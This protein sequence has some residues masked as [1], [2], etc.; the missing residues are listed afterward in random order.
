M[1]RLCS[2]LLVG[3]LVLAGVFAIASLAVGLFGSANPAGADGACTI[4]WAGPT[5]GG[6]WSTTSNWLP[7]RIPA[8]SDVVCIGEAVGGDQG[9][10]GTVVFDGSNGTS[11]TLV[12]ELRSTAPL[13]ITGGELALTDTSATQNVVG[14]FALSG[15]QLGDTTNNQGSF[16]DTGSFS[17]TSGVIEAPTS[18]SPQPVVTDTSTSVPAT[19][20]NVEALSNWNL[21]FDGPMSIT[22]AWFQN[23]GGITE[24]GAATLNNG[25]NISPN[26]NATPA[27]FTLTSTGSLTVGSGSAASA[28]LS[29]PIAASVGAVTV[30]AGDTL[31]VN[32]GGSLGSFAVN[33]GATL[34]LN[35][36]V[37][38]GPGSESGSGT[39]SVVG[40][41]TTIN[42]ALNF[43]GTVTVPSGELYIP[44][45]VSGSQVTNLSLSGGQLGDTTNNQGSL[46]VSGSFSWTSGVIEAP[47]SQS[48]QP[49][50]TDT[51][52]SVPATIG[53]V[54]VLSN[55]NLHFDGPMSITA[56]WFQNGGGITEAGAATLNN[57]AY[58]TANG[59]ATPAPFTLTSTGSLTVG[60][61]S[62]ASATVSV[63]IAAS[64][65]TVTVPAGDTLNVNDGGSLGSFA[66]NAG[67]TLG[68][69]GAM[70]IGPGTKTGS[71]TITVEG[72]ITTINSSLSFPGTV[73]VP[74]GEL[75]IPS[76]VTGSQVGG[77]ALSGGQLG[78]T[79][80]NQ[81]SFTDTGSFSWTSGVIEAPTSQSPQPVV[82]DT[83]TSVP[84]T[85][86][87]VEA[88]SNW[89]LHFDGPMSITAAWFQ[90]GGGITEAGAA[91]LNNGAYITAN[92]NPSP[93][94]FTLTNTAS[95]TVGSGASASATVSVPIAA[96][97]ATVTVPAG[98]TLNLGN[99]PNSGSVGNFTVGNGGTLGLDNVN[100]AASTTNSG[101]GTVNFSGT[102]AD[103]A[104]LDVANA[105]V[106]NGVTTANAALTLAGTLS[107][108]GGELS[109]PSSVTGSQVGGFA[110]SGG[111]LGDTTNNQGSFTDTGS[112]SWTS[113]VIE[114]PTSQSPQ[115][116][117]TDT[118][119]SVP[120]TISNVEALSN[121]NL[122]FDGPMSITAAWFQNGG[123]ITE[124]GAATLNNGA[125]IT[126]NGNPSPGTFTLTNT[127]S[128]TVGS[129][130]SASATVSVP[131]AAAT[132]TVTVPAGDTLN[133]GNAPNSGSVGNFTVGNGG[134][135][136]LDNVNI[137][138]STTNSG[139]GTVNFSGTVA[140][141][142]ALD[143]ANA[144]VI[145]GVTTANAALTLA[146]TLSI[147][148]GE[149]SIPSSVTGSQVGGFALSGGQLGDTTN[150]QGSFTDTGS[151]SWT[152]GVIEA[153]TS[154]SPQP[155]VT[156]TST[157]VP[158]TISNVEALSNWNLHFDGPMSITAAWFQNGG[159]ITEAGAATLNN[160]A[161]ITANGNPSPGTFTLTNTASLTV[162]SGASASATVSVPIAAATATVTVPAGDTLNLG[163]AP[164][165]GSVGNF[166]VGNGGTLGLDNV[167]IAGSTTNSGLGTVN[168]SG[169]VADN[170]ALDVANADV[171]NGVTTANAA[172]TLA[173]TLSITGGE[174]SIP[175]SVTGSQVGGFALSGGQLGD[176]TNNQG[177]FTDT[178]SF[179]WTSGVIEAPTS[180]SP[181]P[182]VTDTST[183]VPA[184]ISNVEA[185]SNWNLHFDGPM[186]I[187]AAW[188][189]NGGGITEAG[190]ATLNNGAYITANGNPS[191]GTFTVTSTGSLTT[192]GPGASASV[193]VPVSN[194]GTVTSGDGDLTLASLTNTGTLNLGKGIVAIS[195]SYAPASGSTL[196]VTVGGTTAGTNYG[197]LQV[198]GNTTLNGTLAITTSNSFTPSI[199]NVFTVSTQTSGTSSGAFSAV[200]QSGTPSGYTYDENG[201]SAGVTLT[202]EPL[203]G[204]PASMSS[205][206]GNNQSAAVGSAFSTGLAVKVVDASNTPVSGVAV[207]FT[208]P[209]SGASGTFATC[210]GGNATA[211][212]CTVSTNA[213]GVAT[214]STLT[215][216]STAGGPYTVAATS[217]ALTAVDYSLTNTASSASSMSANGGTTPQS[218]SVST[219]F[220]TALSVTVVD[221]HSNPVSGVTVTFTAPASGASGT[222]ATCSGGNATA[223]TC[224]VTSNASGVATASAL[225]ANSTSGGPYTVAA[226]ASGLTS[227]DFALTNTAGAAASMSASAGTTPQSTSISTAFGTALAVKV[228][229]SHSNPVSGVSVTFTA[230]ASGA[231][232]T[233][234]TCSGGNAT[235][236]TCT[237]TSNASG[238][239]T[240]STLTANST[241]G[242]PYNVAASASGLTS[243][244]FALTNT[245]GAAATMTA[246]AGT[247]P[248]STVHGSSFGTAL[249][250]KVVDSHSNPVSGVSV[251]FTAP[252][253]GPS[254][255]FATCSGGNA[256]AETCT[257]TSNTSGV[258]TASTLTANS[259]VGGP[260][261]VAATSGALTA[262]DFSLTNNVGSASSM[263]ATAGTTP[264]SAVVNAA[265]ATPLEVKVTDAGSDPV[266]G[267]AVTFTAPAS[268]ASGT[269]ATCAGGNATAE[270][271]TVTTNGS[272]DATA[273]VFTANGVAGAYQVSASSSGLAN[274]TFALTNRPGPP[275]AMRA[276][277]GTPQ[278][279]ASGTAFATPLEVNVVDSE[280]NPVQGAAVTF[281]A[282]SSGA[283]G[284]F[285]S[286]SGGN[287]TAESCTVTTD[288]AGD[289]TASTF[290]ANATVGGPYSVVASSTGVPSKDFS[291]TNTASPL[292]ALLVVSGSP[293][294]AKPGAAFGAPF[295]AKATNAAG[296]PVAGV[297]VTFTA[298]SSGA[299]GT[300]ATC[301]GGNPTPQ[302]CTVTTDATGIATSSV[303][304]A[305]ANG[306]AFTVEASATGLTSAEFNLS[307]SGGYWLVGQDG[308][309]FAYGGA[310]FYG[311]TG[312]L[313]LNKPI[314]GITPTP[315]GQ[316][317][318][319]FASDGGV[320]SYGDAQFHGST[321]SMTL[322]AP[323]VGMASDPITGGYWLVAA[324][325]GVFSF[326]AP[327]EGSM[328]GVPLA[329]PIVGMAAVPNGNGY[330]LVG[331][332]GGVFSFGS[333]TFQGSAG[334]VTLHAPIVGMASDA[335]GNGYWLVAADGGVFAY[336]G[337]PFEG[338]AE[339]LSLNAPVVAMVGDP[340]TGGYWLTAGDGGVFSFGAPFLGS[341][342]GLNLNEPVIAMGAAS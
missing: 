17:W 336:G 209:A 270:S 57:G 45:S 220:G 265:F 331:A 148:G 258:A 271:C 56:A 32:D 150:N 134:T 107:I 123:G 126:A 309:V 319:L 296:Q 188:F 51:S 46:T 144:D 101:L 64:V 29:V 330:W 174:L 139:L 112:F 140:D 132:A 192:T 92:G 217:G 256:T 153:P 121:W 25:A 321:G 149:L 324:D 198:N 157:S 183:S 197:Q 259:T 131:I 312:S 266:A 170:A 48:P 145:N 293:Q 119:T 261:S 6:L 248:Q 277:A 41:I 53:N 78:D 52:T 14:G 323:I 202:Y 137:A 182:V 31:N 333:A 299:S 18:Q 195:S 332:D 13:S 124:A 37:G 55:W 71:G 68:L 10:T 295:V 279:A 307:T 72:N 311:S 69:D 179:S 27:P 141:N 20:S 108:T 224:T 230:P 2:R 308:G 216:N 229:D 268:G 247:T 269:F 54:E 110:L 236:E 103:N 12:D 246:Q 122:H 208:A 267:V 185:L 294:S 42:S 74:T 243:V 264:Q 184:T 142:A 242:G 16:T 297:A 276:T 285:A 181:Q 328:G 135:L 60:S 5:T 206:A 40:N 105:D 165:S 300:F 133:L 274:A 138:A 67:A 62:A 190:A 255:T 89:N 1:R 113:G 234:A 325:G 291:L 111:Q 94:T 272:G 303:F 77:F 305:N 30:P 213:S 11:T 196:A 212:S 35:G 65:G 171:I 262:V 337:A 283:S 177:S 228:V 82:T 36:A 106:I 205:V 39:V 194:A 214:A 50:V 241:S 136:G 245:A 180:Q 79:T 115:P 63:P 219:A 340:S 90:N 287:A 280:E 320:F 316:G 146:G 223:E 172:L 160:G 4:N 239:A 218:A 164:N 168:F 21:H 91:T 86:S 161:Y 233:F 282:P 222:F 117:V 315:T 251:T 97:T 318:W 254:G 102:V 341:A 104:A 7:A 240:A 47:T 232:G 169:T 127:A 163:N 334:G 193:N 159:G 38:I 288:A 225:T 80:N 186:S 85:I 263:A 301:A 130:A 109:I 201:T 273:S 98:D 244:D 26:G 250:V 249:A 215:A 231:S 286:C 284:T 314:V 298:P 116:V 306:G 8:A 203:V 304:T 96:A 73:T 34:G 173:G 147:T 238:I 88:L 84:A 28:T 81:G 23:G 200:T 235:A 152:S 292:H 342:A 59:N 253:S 19:I 289:A 9:M 275:A 118:S 114:A 24:A 290:T 158:A 339:S 335:S 278:S 327:F 310:P 76:S 33:A 61:G 58:I 49:V 178:G 204:P 143:V 329:Q 207:T 313:T 167:N 211:E 75:S 260:Y 326:D 338:S 120:A 155:V 237:V 129:G 128:L 22:A 162:G 199:G 227:V 151:F 87:N 125:Y 189:Q 317:Y 70:G 257:V 44:S 66:V 226:S 95:L 15:G 191:P 175:S 281:T 302:T 322:N 93:G 3:S 252:A 100:I 221:S 156:D 176:T 99:A 210:S 43:P 154:Q 166:T 187:T 83:S